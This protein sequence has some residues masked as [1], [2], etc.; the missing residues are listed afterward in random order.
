MPE[1]Q[2]NEAILAIASALVGWL[3]AH[4]YFIKGKPLEILSKETQRILESLHIAMR[5]SIEYGQLAEFFVSTDILNLTITPS[6]EV[7]SD[8]PLLVRAVLNKSRITPGAQFKMLLSVRDR[9]K[10]FVNPDGATIFDHHGARLHVQN[11][12]FGNILT[13]FSVSETEPPGV[14]ELVVELVDQGLNKSTRTPNK[15][16]YK[17]KFPVT[18]RQG[19]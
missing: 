15:M 16:T 7:G 14:Y 8:V 4:L 1:T 17:L 3:T 19:S 11:A 18:K 13:Q 5:A 6:G 2:P 9:G 12:G 10:D